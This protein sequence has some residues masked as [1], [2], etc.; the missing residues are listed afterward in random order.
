MF[1][2]VVWSELSIT[3]EKWNIS[4]NC[5]IQRFSRNKQLLVVI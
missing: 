1:K 5:A 4:Y 3:Q 2:L